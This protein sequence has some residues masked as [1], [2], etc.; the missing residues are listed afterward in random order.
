MQT[1]ISVH[2]TACANE[3]RRTQVDGPVDEHARGHLRPPSRCQRPLVKLFSLIS[4]DPAPA[5]NARAY[6]GAVPVKR[7]EERDDARRDV[8]GEQRPN[9]DM[10]CDD[11]LQV[12]R[13]APREA[14]GRD[15]R[16]HT[17][18]DGD[19]PDDDL[20]LAGLS[21]LLGHCSRTVSG[22]GLKAFV[23]DGQYCSIAMK[24]TTATPSA[25]RK[26]TRDI[27]STPSRTGSCAES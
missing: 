20:L 14:E 15:E 21:D 4:V 8:H 2:C 26:W 13:D 22:R 5:R 12:L 11:E 6:L 18:E 19:D 9:H 27:T 10:V 16:H 23:P 3:R 17:R 1:S 7:A 25:A 24:L